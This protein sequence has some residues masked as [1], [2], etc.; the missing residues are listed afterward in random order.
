MGA[1]V[2]VT[3]TA[4][5][6]L[7]GLL[8]SAGTAFVPARVYPWLS[9]VSGLLVVLVGFGLLRESARRRASSLPAGTHTHGLL[10][11]PH[12][13]QRG[14]PRP[15]PRRGRRGLASR[16]APGATTTGPA[17]A[18]TTSTCT[19]TSSCTTT[20]TRQDEATAAPPSRRGLVAIG[21]A[22]GLLPSPSALLV[23]LGA[24]A[25]GHPWFGVGLVVAFGLG[26]ASTLAVVG[27]L[28]M[29]LRERAERRLVS[30]PASRLA[31]VLRLVPVLTAVG[32]VVL[33]SALAWR[34]LGSTGL[35]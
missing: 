6:L 32:V 35:R 12:T 14:R 5:V 8:V 17:A 7:L 3:H 23:L 34:G 15:R 24:V 25:L 13:P 10:G 33:G 11:T 20:G 26:M 18:T 19:T 27:L 28:V 22:G 4:G 2:T 31:P 21:L 16:P 29:R 1:T 30:H 9:V